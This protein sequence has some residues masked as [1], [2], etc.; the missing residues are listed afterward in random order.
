MNKQKNGWLNKIR[1]LRIVVAKRNA[2]REKDLDGRVL[3]GPESKALETCSKFNRQKFETI[4]V[5]SKGGRL[6][7]EFKDIGVKVEQ[8]DT[9][10]KLNLYEVLYLYHLIK[11][12]K[13]NI[14]QTHGLRVDFFG[15]LAARLAGVPHIITR[16]VA[17]S[18]HLRSN[19]QKK[20]YMLFD[21]IALKSAAKIIT[22]SKIVENDLVAK[23]GINRN[24]I[25]TIY[26]GVDLGRFSKVTPQTKIK[27]RE[28]FGI[29]SR[30]QVVGMIAQLTNWKGIP[31]FLRAIPLI[32][33]RCPN[34]VFLI[35][36]DGGERRNLETMVETLGISPYVIFAGF[37]RDIPEIISIMDIS[38]L[39]SLREGLPNVLLESMAMRKPIVATDVGGVSELVL[40]NKTGFLIPPRD[41][42]TLSDAI[43][44][45]L[46][47]KEKA[48]KLSRAGRKHVEQ[49]FSLNQM[50]KSYENLYA[51]V[52]EQNL[53]S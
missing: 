52:T 43:I 12:N 35:I 25:V 40:N 2:M 53:K 28:E 33:K 48:N 20:L 32:L 30:K 36:G 45:L 4:I 50:I 29:D 10:S 22:V 46:E 41:S 39:S 8:F 15:F 21:N 47:D 7:K 5:Y 27:M 3:C 6:L 26:N 17:L 49:N 14:V 37:R 38:V 9:K 34:V 16:H 18:H 51:Q 23:Q 1:I 31:Y 11:V 42:T 13:I 44:K 24:K 19:L